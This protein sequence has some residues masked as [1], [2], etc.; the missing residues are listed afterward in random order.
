[1][2]MSFIEQAGGPGKKQGLRLESQQVNEE[3]NGRVEK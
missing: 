2:G 1:M 3:K